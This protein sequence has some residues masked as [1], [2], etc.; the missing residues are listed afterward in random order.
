MLDV[1]TGDLRWAWDPGTEDENAIPEPGQTFTLGS[2]NSW[3]VAS[4]DPDLGL[5]YVPMGNATPD[6]VGMHRD[7]LDERFSSAIV[8]LNGKTGQ[9][10]WSFRTVHYDIWDY[11]IG[12]QPV[13]FDLPLNDGTKAPALAQPTKHGDIY[14]LDRRTGKPLTE[15]EERPVARGTIPSERYSPTQP[16][17]TGFPNMT[18]APLREKDMWGATVFDQLWCRIRYR[19]LD[20][21]G[22]FTPPS[23]RGTLQYPGNFGV[24]DWGSVSIDEKRGLM[25]V[26]ASYMPLSVTLYPK[27]VADKM[28]TPEMTAHAAYARQ[29]GTPYSANAEQFL[30][31]LGLPCN[32]PP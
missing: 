21:R 31:P 7:P 23:T 2:P 13:L 3:T 12:S 20:Y 26:N 27:A 4:V 18:P 14:I 16:F 10:R 24:V 8:A 15:V 22:K 19:Q 6:Y 30:S 32:A 9:R 11:D 29:L 1:I 25:L 28:G 5:V 17:S